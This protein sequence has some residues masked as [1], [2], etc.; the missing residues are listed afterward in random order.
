MNGNICE[1][2]FDVSVANDSYNNLIVHFENEMTAK[3]QCRQTAYRF[4][5][6]FITHILNDI[7][8]LRY[9]HHHHHHHHRHHH[10]QELST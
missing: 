3:F 7:L 10:H 6:G 9:H 2:D 1:C 5:Y 4:N 8:M